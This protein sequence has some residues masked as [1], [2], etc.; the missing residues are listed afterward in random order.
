MGR[1]C[2][3]K[4]TVIQFAHRKFLF[5]GYK[6]SRRADV[7]LYSTQGMTIQRSHKICKFN[8]LTFP[9]QVYKI[10]IN[11]LVRSCLIYWFVTD[12]Y[13]PHLLTFSRCG[14]PAM[15]SRLGASFKITINV[16][17]VHEYLQSI[18]NDRF[19]L[20]NTVHWRYFPLS[21]C[22]HNNNNYFCL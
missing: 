21:I 11:Q 12:N 18:R 13:F 3:S 10:R 1:N 4:W 20:I 17:S 19:C 9:G 14:N 16:R 2:D 6:S 22:K 5:C 7:N 15:I 8:F